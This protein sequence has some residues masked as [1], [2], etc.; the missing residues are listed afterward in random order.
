M[1]NTLHDFN[2]LHPFRRVAVLLLAAVCLSPAAG[3]A[4]TFAR[5]DGGSY[6]VQQTTDY[7]GGGT[8]V[9]LMRITDSDVG[10]WSKTWGLDTD[11][12]PTALA[13][14]ASDAVYVA[15][16]FPSSF[17]GGPFDPVRGSIFLL[18][19][20]SGGGRQYAMAYNWANFDL[21]ARDI[22]V[23]ADGAVYIAGV[24]FQVDVF[25]KA[26]NFA[27]L[28]KVDPSGNIAWA[29]RWA[30]DYNEHYDGVTTDGTNVYCTG[31]WIRPGGV[32]WAVLITSYDADTGNLNWARSWGAGGNAWPCDIELDGWGNLYVAGKLSLG[33]Y[34][35]PY[36]PGNT[37]VNTDAL[38]L[39]FTTAGDLQWGQHFG[40]GYADSPYDLAI[41]YSGEIYIVGSCDFT[42]RPPVDGLANGDPDTDTLFL[43]YAANG[44]PLEHRSNL[45]NVDENYKESF[46]GV[47]FGAAGEVYLYGKLDQD[48]S[49][50]ANAVGGYWLINGSP[51][52]P[53]PAED[54]QCGM[55]TT[56]LDGFFETSPLGADSVR[57]YLT[58]QGLF[59]GIGRWEEIGG[60]PGSP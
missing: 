11:A 9:L 22:C 5:C 13:T 48:E 44:Y 18:K 36:L 42:Y 7:G 46:Y 38:L 39:N 15:G 17:A 45:A 28:I 41:S 34:P 52:T 51:F 54:E 3:W 56:A 53:Q 31:Q 19:Y 35:D 58:D 49:G 37:F 47:D 2:L 1:N 25:N 40:S 60:V 4:E 23:A 57:Q 8:D 21:S 32:P 16:S 55:S 24:A 27:V 6:V 29:K 20:N 33:Y 26:T 43:H 14:D 50:A 12:Y 10:S 59:C 30:V